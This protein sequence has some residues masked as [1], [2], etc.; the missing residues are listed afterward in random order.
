MNSLVSIV[1]PL[2]NKEEYIQRCI[3]SLLSQT[4]EHL[5]ILIVDDGSTDRSGEIADAVRDERLVVIHQEN[6][7]LSEARNTG[8]N[9]SSGDYLVFVDADDTVPKNG[10]KD[11]VEGI[12]RNHADI[13]SGR[14]NAIYANGTVKPSEDTEEVCLQGTGMLECCLRD[15]FMVHHV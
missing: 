12:E 8:I 11:L 3:D 14:F 4:Y 7:G 2:Y 1:V 15:F 13:C 10:V 5:E 6:R 9:H